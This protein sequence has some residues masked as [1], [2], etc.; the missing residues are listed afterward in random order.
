MHLAHGSATTSGAPPRRTEGSRKSSKHRP[1]RPPASPRLGLAWSEDSAA[2]HPVSERLVDLWPGFCGWLGDKWEPAS[3]DGHTAVWQSSGEADRATS[4]NLHPCQ[5]VTLLG[6]RDCH[7]H[8]LASGPPL[9]PCLAT[10]SVK[11][12]LCY[13][14]LLF[15]SGSQSSYPSTDGC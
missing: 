13:S 5:F 9:W 4:A 11:V 14:A 3:N 15:L 8:L 1:A 2:S 6:Q 10:D 7:F 12:K